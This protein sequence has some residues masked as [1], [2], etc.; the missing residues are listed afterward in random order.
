[1]ASFGFLRRTLVASASR[2]VA[3]L[4][5]ATAAAGAGAALAGSLSAAQAAAAPTPL[6]VWGEAAMPSAEETSPPIE[7][8]AGGAK[9]EHVAFGERYTVALDEKG[10]L[11]LWTG[12]LGRVRPDRSPPRRVAFSEPLAALATTHD[13][14]VVVTR[15]GRALCVPAFRAWA[16]SLKPAVGADAAAPLSL[17]QPPAVLA[18]DAARR[19]IVSAAAGA[20]H[21]VLLSSKGEVLACGANE[22]GQLGLGEALVGPDRVEEPRLVRGAIDGQRVVDVACGGT[23][24]FARTADGALF[25]FGDD[26][27]LQ[28]GVRNSSVTSFRAEA[29][30]RAEP[31]A[32]DLLAHLRPDQSSPFA[33]RSAVTVSAVAAGASHSLFALEH[34]PSGETRVLGCGFGRFGQLGDGQFRHISAVREL[35]AINNR[36]EWDESAQRVVPVRT[37][38]LA[39]GE[40]HS[41]A[42]LSTG[43]VMVWGDNVNG[44]LGDGSRVGA[45]APGRLKAFTGVPIERIECSHGSCAAWARAAGAVN[46]ARSQR[47]WW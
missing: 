34:A 26:R 13:D 15:R 44:Q 5:A 12:P 14:L 16:A 47:G 31:V 41:A 10:Q 3:R 11:W 24:T 8:T 6:F 22:R 7:L 38:A 4:A 32:V 42:V 27:W 37:S 45:P 23:H 40:A 19:R 33:E 28:L 2:R 39:A 35:K 25:A 9:L 46:G 29:D 36:R 18:G 21:V 20:R 17:P 1:M 43:D 30:H